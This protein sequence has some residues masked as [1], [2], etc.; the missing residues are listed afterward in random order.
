MPNRTKGPP[1]K[2]DARD[3]QRVAGRR[4]GAA[5]AKPTALVAHRAEIEGLL[6]KALAELND[7]GLIVRGERGDKA[8]PAWPI[9]REL[10][11]LLAKVQE[12][13]EVDEVAEEWETMSAAQRFHA[14]K[15]SKEDPR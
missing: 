11:N 14:M 1:R 12:V 9:A 15:D 10:L 5:V 2:P 3:A 4:R 13:E 8:S 7:E 6:A